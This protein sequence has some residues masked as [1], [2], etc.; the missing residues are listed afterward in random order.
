MNKTWLWLVVLGQLLLGGCDTAVLPTITNIPSGEFLALRCI[1][2]GEDAEGLPLEACGCSERVQEGDAS[3]VRL[4]GRLECTCRTASGEAVAFVEAEACGDGVCPRMV[5]GDWVAASGGAGLPCI[6]RR[7]GAIRGYVGS[8]AQQRV[9]FLGLTDSAG[10]ATRRILDIDQT[11]PGVTGLYV[12]D[13]LTDMETS[14]SGN[15]ILSVVSNGMSGGLGVLIEDGTE[16]ARVDLGYGPLLDLEVFPRSDRV[17]TRTAGDEP[18]PP[19]AYVSAP[20]AQAVLEVDL[21][22]LGLVV[23]GEATADDAVIGCYG[24]SAESECEH[25]LSADAIEGYPGRLALSADGARV[26]VGYTDQAVVTEFD[27]LNA[28]EVRQVN[29]TR[30]RP[31]DDGYLVRVEAPQDDP[32]CGDGLDNDADGVVDSADPDCAALGSEAPNPRCPQESQCAD[33]ADNDADGQVDLDDEDCLVPGQMWEGPPPAC[34]DGEDNDGD[35]LVDRADPGCANEADVDEGD[36]E[37]RYDDAGNAVDDILCEDGLDNDAD[38]LVDEQ[39]PGCHDPAAAVRY[40]QERQPECGDGIDNDRDGRIDFGEDDDCYAAG[41]SMEGES[42]LEVGPTQLVVVEAPI[43]GGRSFL[44]VT[45]PG[46]YLMVVD[47]DR[48]VLEPRVSRLRR[49]P[50]TMTVREGDSGPSLLTFTEDAILRSIDAL[51]QGELRTTE[52]HTVFAQLSSAAVANANNWAAQV[53]ADGVAVERFY[54]VHEGTAYGVDLG[55]VCAPAACDAEGAE[56][57]ANQTCIG[58]RCLA[59]TCV[60]S[61]D[62]GDGVCVGGGCTTA[63]TPGEADACGAGRSCRSGPHA[64]TGGDGRY[65]GICAL[66]C[67]LTSDGAVTID[68]A[69]SP[70]FTLPEDPAERDALAVAVV[71]SGAADPIVLQRGIFEPFHGEQNIIR[72]ALGRT[73]RV[74]AAPSASFDGNETRLD[75]AI[76]PVFCQFPQ[77]RVPTEEDSADEEVSIDVTAACI[78]AGQTYSCTTGRL[79]AESSTAR[80]ARL[81]HRVDVVEE[82]QVIE[83][84]PF[85]LPSDTFSVAF[86][87]ILPRSNSESG[88]FGGRES[89]EAWTLFDYNANYCQ[90]GVEVGDVVVFDPFV[91]RSSESNCSQFDPPP[92]DAL[93]QNREALR[94]VVASLT[95]HSL[96][97]VRDERTD[98]GQRLEAGRTVPDR[99]APPPVAPTA[100]CAAQ[101]MSYRIRAGNDQWLVTGNRVGLRHPWVTGEGVCEALPSRSQRRSRFQLG[102]AFENEWFRFRLGTY[103]APVNQCSPDASASPLAAL[104]PV[105]LD[106]AFSFTLTAGR[107]TSQLS[108]AAVL[109]RQMR[110]LPNEDRLFVVDGAID[111]VRE[112]GGFDIF[113]ERM[114]ELRRFE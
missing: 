104:P 48:D 107:A 94:Y 71:D 27:R 82:I 31:C 57:Q 3:F 30:R 98:Y 24:L 54:I 72:R 74:A 69:V 34:A 58:G 81:Q 70:T 108:G 39:D 1:T 17:L 10:N 50:L 90:L 33:G 112:I 65:D 28:G 16:A 105:M 26:Y 42:N 4:M 84:N 61:A 52:G 62:C 78:P 75:P 45:E 29:L 106:L 51:A 114:L 101:A 63:C 12:D 23:A 79:E 89:D 111:N 25:T 18:I 102:D 2:A 77:V 66:A 8:N 68:G 6:P 41:D 19:R 13:V 93:S 100:E 55:D 40:R 83:S 73:N 60:S 59:A 92:T 113:R 87:G 64:E 20:L 109:P 47:L 15:A 43:D 38:G 5:D 53:A 21:D 67:G 80:S 85:R 88:V 56:C 49:T 110:W 9:L 99:P 95:P 22:V 97:L 86:E 32:T 46:G 36:L 91:P 103:A 37:R 14:P 35:G 96:Q 44:Y 7:N 11:I 76:H